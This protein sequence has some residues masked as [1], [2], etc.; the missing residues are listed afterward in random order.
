LTDSARFLLVLSTCPDAETAQRIAGALVEGQLAACVSV[1]PGL[2]STYRWEGAVET[3]RE[4]LLLI[5][6]RAECYAEVESAV[7]ALHPYTVPEVLGVPVSEGYA[8]YLL[9]IETCVRMPP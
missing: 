9:W 1:L 5:K 2:Q 3:A 4:H 8:G 6:T 7:R